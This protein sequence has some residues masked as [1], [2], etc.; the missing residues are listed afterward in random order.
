MA[1]STGVNCRMWAVLTLTNSLTF[2]S[3][4]SAAPGRP[5]IPKRGEKDFEPSVEGGSG[6]QLHV[7]DR[8]RASMLEALKAARN[9]S[10]FVE[11]RFCDTPLLIVESPTAN[12]LATA[13]GIP[14]YFEPM[15]RQPVEC[16]LGQWV[17][18]FL[19]RQMKH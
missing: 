19:A 10:R 12:L 16:T 4:I 11:F 13:S 2:K 3:F 7:L 6:L 14:A 1:L 5:V 17:T 15:S 8:A 9:T 18:Q